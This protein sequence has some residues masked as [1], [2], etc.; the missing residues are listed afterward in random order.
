VGDEPVAW[1]DALSAAYRMTNSNRDPRH[2]E[3]TLH[4]TSTAWVASSIS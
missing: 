4:W 2:D 1:L 3:L